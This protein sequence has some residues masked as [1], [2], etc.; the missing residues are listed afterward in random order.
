MEKN[1]FL[2]LISQ[3]NPQLKNK[4]I[5]NG[6]LKIHLLKENLDIYLLICDET[7][8]LG[9]FKNDGSYDQNR[10]LNSNTHDSLIWA[11]SLFENIKSFIYL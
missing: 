11:N 5:K 4:C 8:N 9:L 3:I 10:I 7:M 2:G 6:S 1:I